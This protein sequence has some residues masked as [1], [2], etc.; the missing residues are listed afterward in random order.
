MTYV[1]RRV[2]VISTQF[3]HLDSRDT[4]AIQVSGPGFAGLQIWNV[5][6]APES[7]DGTGDAIHTLTFL[8]P[9]TIYRLRGLQFPEFRLG[10]CWPVRQTL[11][12]AASCLGA[13]ISIKRLQLQTS[14]PILAEEFSIWLSPA[15]PPQRRGSKRTNTPVLIMS[16]V[17]TIF[18]SPHHHPT[19]G[20]LRLDRMDQER[21]RR[22]LRPDLSGASVEEVAFLVTSIRHALLAF[23]PRS[24]PEAYAKPR[25]NI[26]CQTKL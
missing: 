13:A 16:F 5:Y 3:P 24:R 25:W 14:P 26:H 23:A 9:W 4:I 12:R 17:T 15:L 11:R 1:L 7:S 21:F 6:N 18:V 19:R 10:P 8:T 22:L 20:K 2:S